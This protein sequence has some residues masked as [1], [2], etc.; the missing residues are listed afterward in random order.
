M[1]KWLKQFENKYEVKLSDNLGHEEIIFLK[2]GTD[3][4][5]IDLN[6]TKKIVVLIV[7]S[8]QNNEDMK[9]LSGK[10]LDIILELLENLPNLTYL[11]KKGNRFPEDETLIEEVE[12]DE[13]RWRVQFGSQIFAEQEQKLNGS[14]TLGCHY[15]K[16][17][18]KMEK[19]HRCFGSIGNPRKFRWFSL[20]DFNVSYAYGYIKLVER[21]KELGIQVIDTY[22]LES[23][24][25]QEDYLS[26]GYL[27]LGYPIIE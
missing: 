13:N 3:E 7:T 23:K 20:S 4:I 16:K 26:R 9:S 24:D 22:G 2:N 14:N 11:I 27:K 12:W 1:D 8:S 17:E 6:T 5:V 18:K 15:L 25:D 21:E 10:E 19:T